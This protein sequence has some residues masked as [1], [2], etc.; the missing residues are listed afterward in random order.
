MGNLIACPG[1]ISSSSSSRNSQVSFSATTGMAEVLWVLPSSCSRTE[2]T[3]ALGA[4]PIS[5]R[6][7]RARWVTM[8]WSMPMGQEALQRLQAVQR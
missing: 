4:M 8:A 2:T 3:S 7:H 6:T 1:K 5:A